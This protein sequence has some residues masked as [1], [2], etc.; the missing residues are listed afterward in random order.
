MGDECVEHVRATVRWNLVIDHGQSVADRFL[1]CSQATTGT[2]F[3]DQPYWDLVSLLDLLLDG[4]DP[5]DIKPDDLQRF[6]DYAA[7]S[8][9][10]LKWRLGSRSSTGMMGSCPRAAGELL[11]RDRY[12][13]RWRG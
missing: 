11:R 7:A 12:G 2:A 8:L 6:E 13:R 3:D 9:S 1:A 4:D 5:G 10:Q